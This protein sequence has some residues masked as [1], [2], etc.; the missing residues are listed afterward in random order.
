MAKFSDPRNATDVL[1]PIKNRF[2]VL[3]SLTEAEIESTQKVSTRQKTYT[4]KCVTHHLP[5]AKLCKK[6]KICHHVHTQNCLAFSGNHCVERGAI[7]MICTK[8][9]SCLRKSTVTPSQKYNISDK[10][11]PCF[12]SRTSMRAVVR[13]CRKE[14]SLVQP[15]QLLSRSKSNFKTKQTKVGFLKRYHKHFKFRMQE[16]GEQGDPCVWGIQ[17][18]W[19]SRVSKHSHL[20]DSMRRKLCLS[21]LKDR[22][23]K[24]LNSTH[25]E[26]GDHSHLWKSL[27]QTDR[28]LRLQNESYLNEIKSLDLLHVY[29]S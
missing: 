28:I 19:L 1:T 23:D 16:A 2:W 9:K 8:H 22:W 10:T 29:L 21:C 17:V 20:P 11:N 5:S 4:A 24:T 12:S 13:R 27:Y 7:N 26:K 14:H 25:I 3:Q 6:P 15:P 18:T